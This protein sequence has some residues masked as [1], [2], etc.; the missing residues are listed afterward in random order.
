MDNNL[1]QDLLKRGYKRLRHLT[2]GGDVAQDIT[3]EAFLKLLK[4]EADK[5]LPSDKTGLRK[6]WN[7]ILRNTFI[8]WYNKNRRSKPSFSMVS[9]E[10]SDGNPVDIA[11]VYAAPE[12]LLISARNYDKADCRHR[13]AGADGFARAVNRLPH[14]QQLVFNLR[15]IEGLSV[16]ETAFVLDIAK[17]T[18][19]VHDFRARAALRKSWGQ[20]KLERENDGTVASMIP[21]EI[22]QH[23]CWLPATAPALALQKPTRE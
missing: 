4:L 6:L 21:I 8:D 3:H 17:S 22:T 10:D 13:S 11:D 5:G 14:R 12:P 7:T 9:F 18:V 16:K 15:H 2:Y 19:K 23:V 1:Q 20:V